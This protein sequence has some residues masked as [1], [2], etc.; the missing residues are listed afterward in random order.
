MRALYHLAAQ[1]ARRYGYRYVETPALELTELFRRTSGETSDVVRKEMYTFEDR[2]GRLLTLRPEAT[3]P[4]V[5]A[6]LG[7]GHGLATPF[8][9]F[10]I[11]TMWRYGRPQSGRL[12]EFRQ[13]DIEVIGEGGP[14]ADVEVIAV[15]HRFLRSAQ[16]G[17]F[18]LQ[19][20]SIGDAKCRPAYRAELVAFLRANQDR[21]TDEHREHFEDNPMRV[22][23]CKDEN[24]RAVAAEAPKIVD[25]LCAE[26]QKHFD[27]VRKELKEEGIEAV[28]TPTLV[29]GLDYYTRTTF[30]W[31]SPRLAEAQQSVGGGGRY[32]GLAEVLG[33]PPTPGVGF[34]I[35]LE[36]VHLAWLNLHRDEGDVDLERPDAFVVG[37]DQGVWPR[38]RKVV[39]TLREAG[40][41]ADYPLEH[42][43]IRGQMRMANVAGARYAVII[44]EKEAR[45]GTVTLRELTSG[46]QEELDLDLAIARMSASRGSG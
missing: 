31:V 12:R 25:R 27:E 21:L 41:S 11:G 26:C 5:R 40:L 29:R 43:P 3:A 23:D 46:E 16:V 17:E 18:Q 33:G 28:L 7:R 6:F 15:G 22:L 36:R 37:V 42:R 32:D 8:K 35:G 14:A 9:V 4:I 30:E 10:T 20:S 45:A 19:I 34:A 24:C 13:F 38:V 44:G 1:V 2:G 39:R